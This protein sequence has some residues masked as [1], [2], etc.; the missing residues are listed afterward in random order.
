MHYATFTQLCGFLF[1]YKIDGTEKLLFFLT[2]Q[3]VVQGLVYCPQLLISSSAFYSTFYSHI[4]VCYKQDLIY[5]WY[6]TRRWREMM[7]R[8]QKKKP[9]VIIIL[10]Y[11]SLDAHIKAAIR[12]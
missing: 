2:V 4:Y 9:N 3:C 5:F 1:T 11:L 8:K 12:S 6:T 7:Y 10:E